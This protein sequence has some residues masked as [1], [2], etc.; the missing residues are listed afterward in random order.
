MSSSVDYF[1]SMA[2][3]ETEPFKANSNWSKLFFSFKPNYFLM[4][5]HSHQT[6]DELDEAQTSKT[7]CKPDHYQLELGIIYIHGDISVYVPVLS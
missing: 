7:S 5:A 1:L 3:R 6:K 4:L 2:V